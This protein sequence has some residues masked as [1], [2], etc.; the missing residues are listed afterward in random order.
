MRANSIAIATCAALLVAASASWANS[1][2]EIGDATDL[3]PGQ[4][5]EGVG[6]VNSIFGSFDFVGDADL[7]RI[8]IFDASIFSVATSSSFRDPQL[9][10][11]DMGGVG[12]AHNDD[13]ESPASFLSKFPAGDPAYSG[14]PAG[15][16][17]LGISAWNNDPVD[18]S[19]NPLFPVTASP[20]VEGPINTNPLA[21]WTNIGGTGNYELLLQ[22]ARFSRQIPEPSAAV[23]F[24]VGF[25]VAGLKQRRRR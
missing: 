22:G 13:F 1:F 11:F 14:L 17:L 15:D 8:T 12:I 9:W 16:Y 23:L 20:N 24:A 21:G 2:T 25:G 18:A 10:L 7:Y 4:T 5:V 3:A 6:V 19:D